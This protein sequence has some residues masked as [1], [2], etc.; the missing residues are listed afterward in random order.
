MGLTVS[1][2]I[3]PPTHPPTHPP[4]MEY[5]VAKT[6]F[7]RLRGLGVMPLVGEWFEEKQ[8]PTKAVRFSSPPPFPLPLAAAPSSFLSHPPIHLPI[9]SVHTQ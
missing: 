6:S 4:R 9:H 2:L 3:H 1:L 7:Q 8:F 5:E